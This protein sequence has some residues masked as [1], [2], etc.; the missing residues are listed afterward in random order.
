MTF[1]R[2]FYACFYFDESVFLQN[3]HLKLFS[4]NATFAKHSFEKLAQK[5]LFTKRHL[6]KGY[7]KATFIKR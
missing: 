1:K 5:P 4:L 2:D 3:A 7:F 6:C